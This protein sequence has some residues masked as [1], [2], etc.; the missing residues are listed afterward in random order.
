MKSILNTISIIKL[1]IKSKDT[2]E[3]MEEM[4]N[5]TSLHIYKKFKEWKEENNIYD[6]TYSS[7]LLFKLRSNTL[8][9]NKR[10]RYEYT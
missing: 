8:E 10:I 7:E 9:L 5:K 2:I 4:K 3:W 1:N 6:N